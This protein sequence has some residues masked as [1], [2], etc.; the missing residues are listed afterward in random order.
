MMR[1]FTFAFG[2]FFITTP[3]LAYTGMSVSDLEA[4][5]NRLLQV[6]DTIRVQ[7]V[8]L[9]S[10]ASSVT[11][12]TAAGSNS[13]STSTT[14]S[15]AECLTTSFQMSRGDSGP[16]VSRLQEFLTAES[17][18]S[19]G[20]TGYYGPATEAGVQAWQRYHDIVSSGSPS[21]TGYGRVGPSTLTAM[22]AGCAT[23]A[24]PVGTPTYTNP[25]PT[26]ERY[27]FALNVTR[28]TAPLTVNA[29]IAINGSTC[30]SYALDWGDGTGG[31]NYNSGQSSNCGSL[32][33]NLQ[34]SH[35]YTTPGT[36]I[37]TLKNGRA[38]LAN[39]Q[40]VGQFTVE[41]LSN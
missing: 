26:I 40:Q 41:V 31:L 36:Y 17:V 30:T 35:T 32:P 14:P 8:Q 19:A 4:E 34:P 39:I 2:I 11:T 38:P 12:L 7:L 24:N 28:G 5:I 13:P 18:Y 9:G 25:T 27:S 37:V 3:S 23:V 29:S 22:K 15:T 21:T 20:V 33:I 1:F 16:A 10:D 6:A